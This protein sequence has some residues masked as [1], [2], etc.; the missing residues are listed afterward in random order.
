M[1][2]KLLKTM[3]FNY[4]SRSKANHCDHQDKNNT[5]TQQDPLQRP[6]YTNN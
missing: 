2:W 5:K 3:P 1:I 6:L 4:S